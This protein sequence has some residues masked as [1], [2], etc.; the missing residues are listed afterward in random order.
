MSENKREGKKM[1]VVG[2]IVLTVVGIIVALVLVVGVAA[3]L[4]VNA[5]TTDKLPP[6]PSASDADMQSFLVGAATEV[7]T[8]KTITV[9][10]KNID[11]LLDEVKN[12]T[13]GNDMFEIQELFCKLDGS[14][15]TIYGR[16]L[17]KEI[18]VKGIKL[19]INRVA[20]IKAGFNVSFEAPE[21]VIVIDEVS[22]GTINIPRSIISS[23]LAKLT[24]PEGMRSE[25]GMIYYDTSDLDAKID[26]ILAEKITTSITQ[27]EAVS[28]LE[29]L[30]GADVASDLANKLAAAATEVAT[31]ATNVELNGASITDGKLVIE[32]K[33]L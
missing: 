21:I 3:L 22:C 6:A 7:L 25:N 26:A 4:T 10:D 31:S 5:A 20:P 13:A 27:S 2:K 23:V 15:G 11:T 32:G 12:S 8:N 16:I 30:F 17:I 29:Q 1:G 9:E 19:K 14:K 24:L 18:T 28:K 33:V